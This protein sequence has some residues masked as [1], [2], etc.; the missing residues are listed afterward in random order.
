MR[1]F[2]ILAVLAALAFTSLADSASAQTRRPRAE[3]PLESLAAANSAARQRP[4][5]QGFQEARQIYAYEPGALYELYTSPN[6]VSTILLE[7]GDSLNTIAV[8]DTSRWMVTQADAEEEI[9]GRTIVLVKPQIANLRTNIVLI[10]NRR[11]YLV[12]PI[13]QTGGA[14]SAQVAWTYPEASAAHLSAPLC[15]GRPD[16]EAANSSASRL[17]SGE[18]NASAMDQCTHSLRGPSRKPPADGRDSAA[19]ALRKTPPQLT[20][21]LAGM[22]G[23]KP[24]K[25]ADRSA[26]LSF[27]QSKL[28]GRRML[29]LNHLLADPQ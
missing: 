17:C 11:T 21:R 18:R 28:P 23:T 26:G 16:F 27:R 19:L 20:H 7:P 9:E 4:S 1:L 12:E 25:R 8:G 22:L 13:A 14:Y 3:S 5:A 29:Q 24:R 15:A 6:Y 2:P 10:T